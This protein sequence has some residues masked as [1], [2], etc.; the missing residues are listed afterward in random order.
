MVTNNLMAGITYLFSVSAYNDVG[1][2][3]IS[4]SQAIMAAKV[5][6]APINVRM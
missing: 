3:P 1:E 2:G 6:L 4:S 5:P